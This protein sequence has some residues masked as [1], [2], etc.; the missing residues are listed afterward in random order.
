M[1]LTHILSVA[2]VALGTAACEQPE[3]LSSDF[4]NSVNHNMS[5]HVINPEPVY[6]APEIPDFNGVRAAGA[7]ERYETNTVFEPEQIETTDVGESAD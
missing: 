7:M 2:V 1:K 5:L 4:G 6:L 3:H